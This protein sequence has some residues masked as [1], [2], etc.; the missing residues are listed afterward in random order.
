MT[1]EDELKNLVQ[2]YFEAL[3]KYESGDRGKLDTGDYFPEL[4]QNRWNDINKP[5]SEKE[6]KSTLFG[7]SPFKAPGPNGIPASFYQRAWNKVGEN[8]IKCPAC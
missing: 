1:K 7:M 6:I 3:F 2:E 5:M 8:V 4:S